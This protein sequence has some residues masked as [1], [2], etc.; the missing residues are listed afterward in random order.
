MVKKDAEEALGHARE[1]A[2]KAR[3]EAE[4][5]KQSLTEIVAR[6]QEE[7]RK[8][9]EEAEASI[10]MAN[11]TMKLARQDIIGMTIDEITKTRQELGARHTNA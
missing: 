6:T 11:E 2:R 3:G 1:E 4:K 10:L 7:C 8:A 5:A 9:K